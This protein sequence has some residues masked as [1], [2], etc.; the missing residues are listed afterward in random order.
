M[1]WNRNRARE[2]HRTAH[3]SFQPQLECLEARTLLDASGSVAAAVGTLL[4]DLGQTVMDAVHLQGAALKQ[5][6]INVIKDAL[7]VS[8]ELKTPPTGGNLADDLIVLEAAQSMTET[9]VSIVGFGLA[10]C[11]TP[12]GPETGLPIA[13]IGADYAHDGAELEFAAYQQLEKDFISQFFSGQ[14]SAPTSTPTPL[15]SPSASPKTFAGTFSGDFT[16]DGSD[17]DGRGFFSSNLGGKANMT[18][19]PSPKGGYD[20]SGSIQLSQQIPDP[21]GIDDFGGTYSFAFHVASLSGSVSFSAQNS[22]GANLPC[23]GTFF[24]DGS[25][26]GFWSLAESYQDNSDQGGGTFTLH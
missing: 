15:P 26:G 24:A 9:G 21:A 25:F 12:A 10:L 7:N 5:D 17:D 22:N 23:D 20:V 2:Q 11:D 19:T 4:H 1:F 18:V 8:T 16:S 14:Q 3:P 13:I 6:G